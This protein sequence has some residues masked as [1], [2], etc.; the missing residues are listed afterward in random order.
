[1]FDP[2]SG[3]AEAADVDGQL[4]GHMGGIVSRVSRRAG[5]LAARRSRRNRRNVSAKA[6]VLHRMQ[7]A[8]HASLRSSGRRGGLQRGKGVLSRRLRGTEVVL[9]YEKWD[10][11]IYILKLIQ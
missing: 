7:G 2:F 11:W 8:S 3:D 4:D 9:R 10:L 6:Q 1:M 5:A